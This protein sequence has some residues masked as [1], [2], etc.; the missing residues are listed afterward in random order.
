MA[1]WEALERLLSGS[2]MP[3]GHCYLWTPEMVWLQVVANLLIGG[4]YVAISSALYVIVR[5]IEDLPFSWMYF[6]FGVFMAAGVAPFVVSN[7]MNM[8]VASYA[9]LNCDGTAPTP[10]VV[11]GRSSG[12]PKPCR[13]SLESR[14]LSC[15]GRPAPGWT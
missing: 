10:T 3:L 9:G 6:A 13:N 8:I 4:A 7:P 11:T 15:P 14:P 2:F 5:R 12:G 1:M